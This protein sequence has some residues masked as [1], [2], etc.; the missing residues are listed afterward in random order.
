MHACTALESNRAQ[1]VLETC[2]GGKKKKKKKLGTTAA[3]TDA[4]LR[5]KLGSF[6]TQSSGGNLSFA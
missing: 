5:L 6:G 2:S 3:V 4:V 1:R